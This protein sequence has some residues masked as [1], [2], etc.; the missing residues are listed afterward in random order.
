MYHFV[1]LLAPKILTAQQDIAVPVPSLDKDH[2]IMI[3]CR[4][5]GYP[6]PF[7]NWVFDDMKLNSTRGPL[8]GRDD[9]QGFII[10]TYQVFENGSLL[11]FHPKFIE[12]IEHSNFTCVASSFV[13]EDRQSHFLFVGGGK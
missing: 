4:T 9:L 5:I 13:G 12:N 1:R 3:S 10:Y 7:I 6:K 2:R 11:I 8:V